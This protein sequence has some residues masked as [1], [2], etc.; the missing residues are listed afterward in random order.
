[1]R[2]DQGD[3]LPDTRKRR[4]FARVDKMSLLVYI[5]QIP[6]PQHIIPQIEK[7]EVGTNSGFSQV[8][9]LLPSLL[10]SYYRRGQ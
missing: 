2:E 7:N 10:P 9:S 4:C 6:L 5:I 3:Q 8:T 1:M